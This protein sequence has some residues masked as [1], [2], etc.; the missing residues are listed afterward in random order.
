MK[1]N[2]LYCEALQLTKELV[3]IPS[4][5]SSEGGEAAIAHFLENKLRELPY[6]QEHPERVVLQPLKDDPLERSNVFGV[7]TGEKSPSNRTILLHAHMDTV[8]IEDYGALKSFAFSCDELTKLMGEEAPD[9][10][11]RRDARSGEWLFGRGV[12]DMKCGIA[13][14]YAVLHYLTEHLNE[15]S[16][17]IVWMSNPVEENQHTGIRNAVEL[18]E[19]W[20][21]DYQL[22]Y[23]MAINND[24]IAPAY[25]G[26]TTNYFH[27]GSV[28]KILPCFYCVGKPTHAG[29]ALEGVSVSRV[30]A[31]IVREMDSNTAYCDVYHGEYTSPP[32]P[33]KAEDLKQSYDVQTAHD[34]F[35]YF[36]YLI[37]ARS[38]SEIFVS[39]KKVAQ[40]ALQKTIEYTNAQYRNY[41][42][43]IG[44]EYKKLEITTEVLDYHELYQR[45]EGQYEGN[46]AEH[47]QEIAEKAMQANVDA[48]KI[49]RLI[50]SELCEMAKIYQPTVVVF[51]A[52][53][54]C[55]YNTLHL[56]SEKEKVLFDTLNQ[57]LKNESQEFDRNF[58]LNH[59]FPV[60]S[61]SSYLK[62]DDD[63][64][65]VQ[66]LKEN[67][68]AMEQ[69]FSMPM[70][71]I[72]ALNIPAVN[73]GCLGKDAHKWTERVNLPYTF[74]VLPKVILHAVLKWTEEG[75][76]H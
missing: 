68:P 37:H 44:A 51:L 17:N 74:G 58:Q 50:V 60:L 41:C 35:V 72:Q 36:N 32:V 54:Y 56:E 66:V 53:P 25:P 15:F 33:L 38:M 64:D 5:N 65:S 27:A 21:H 13:V 49:S 12:A 62:T 18:L 20:K 10:D 16:G 28:G 8:G 30:L 73:F 39:L 75:F 4:V 11:V 31:E 7:V 67:F 71:T 9:E 40:N 29:E 69:L 1:V 55:P 14:H 48:R 63:P 23:I 22:D 2:D 34:A 46:L 42:R 19:K 45:V 43:M 61:D 47:V 24:Y 57:F 70:E 6:F 59:F 76:E 26:D 52:P 3:A